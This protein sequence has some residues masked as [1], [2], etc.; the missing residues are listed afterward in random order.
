MHFTG[1]ATQEAIRKL[2]DYLEMGIGDFPKSAGH[3]STPD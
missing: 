1:T 3:S 2:I